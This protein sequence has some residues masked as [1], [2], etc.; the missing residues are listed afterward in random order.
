MSDISSTKDGQIEV[1]AN[2]DTLRYWKAKEAMRNAELRLEAQAAT[3]QALEARATSVLGWLL[4]ILTTIAGAA[5]IKLNA[6]QVV[7]G[8]AICTAFV[9][10][11]L[12]LIA[13]TGAIWPKDWCVPGYDPS[14]VTSECENELQQIDFLVCGY[15]RGIAENAQFLQRSAE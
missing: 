5:L 7:V 15:S 11:L 2:K 4:A 8:I 12:T 3:V 14:V 10:G 9:P 6:G 13:A 1:G